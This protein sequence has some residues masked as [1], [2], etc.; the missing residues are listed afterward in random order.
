MPTLPD[1]FPLAQLVDLLPSWAWYALFAAGMLAPLAGLVIS[2]SARTM[3]PW[4]RS[5]TSIFYL[6]ALPLAGWVL[7]DRTENPLGVCSFII[8]MPVGMILGLALLLPTAPAHD[9]RGFEVLP[10]RDDKAR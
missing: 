2:L 9:P 3:T 10:K 5:A 7:F 1:S 8:L 4:K 6:F